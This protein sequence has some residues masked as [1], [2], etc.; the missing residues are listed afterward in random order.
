MILL[1]RLAF[2]VLHEIRFRGFK[3]LYLIVL[4]H[5]SPRVHRD[6]LH[7]PALCALPAFPHRPLVWPVSYIFGGA[8][9]FALRFLQ[10]AESDGDFFPLPALRAEVP[11][12]IAVHLVFADDLVIAVFQVKLECGSEQQAGA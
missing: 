2:F 8:L 10:I 7:L 3:R 5:I 4:N 6:P 12:A 11:D 1:K 9:S